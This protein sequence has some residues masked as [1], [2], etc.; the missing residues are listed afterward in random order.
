MER[1]AKST[2]QDRADQGATE[3]AANR[4]RMTGQVLGLDALSPQGPPTRLGQPRRAAAR[5]PGRSVGPLPE[6]PRPWPRAGTR[7]TALRSQT[8]PRARHQHCGSALAEPHPLDGGC[9]LL[10]LTRL[11]FF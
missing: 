6:M 4:M 9:C 11:R 10:D 2:E 1:A 5:A 3:R 7:P 8:E